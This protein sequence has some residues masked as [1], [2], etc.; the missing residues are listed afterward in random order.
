VLQFNKR[1]LATICTVEEMNRSLNPHNWPWFEASA[2]SGQGVFETLKGVSKLTLLSL[3]KR[4]TRGGEAA[5]APSRPAPR[6]APA[7][8]P[9]PPGKPPQP[10][11]APPPPPAP[12]TPAAPPPPPP[13]PPPH[14]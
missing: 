13:P 12:P 2:L 14:H 9:A 11:P 3:K 1:D 10:A 7:P 4:L 5:A 6:P 8:A